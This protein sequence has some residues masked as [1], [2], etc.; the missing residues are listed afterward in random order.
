MC[1]IP[2]YAPEE[3][4]GGHLSASVVHRAS[5]LARRSLSALQVAANFLTSKFCTS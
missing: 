2:A 3:P 5:V 4:L 1:I